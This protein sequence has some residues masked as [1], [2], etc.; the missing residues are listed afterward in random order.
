[1]AATRTTEVR[2]VPRLCPACEPFR[3]SAASLPHPVFLLIHH[4]GEEPENQRRSDNQKISADSYI[5]GC[6]NQTAEYRQKFRDADFLVRGKD[7]EQKCQTEEGDDI[8]KLARLPFRD[9]FL[10]SL[11]V[12]QEEVVVQFVGIGIEE[13]GQKTG[14]KNLDIGLDLLCPL[15]ILVDETEGIDVG[16]IAH[17]NEKTMNANRIGK[18]PPCRFAQRRLK[19]GNSQHRFESG[20]RYRSFKR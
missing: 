10:S 1:M 3:G 11:V 2:I 16:Q 19:T 12:R 7:N 17:Q 6:K 15:L 18:D 9:I 20:F 8:G 14:N 5:A 13:S 4:D